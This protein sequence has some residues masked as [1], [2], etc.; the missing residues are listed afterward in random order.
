M[1]DGTLVEAS[2]TLRWLG[3]WFDRK[4][5]FKHHVKTKAASAMR[6]FLAL[7]RLGNTERGLSQ[8]AL[9]QLYQTCVT[10]IS[11]FGAEVWWN[12]QT[13]Y[14][15]QLQKIQ[16][17]AMRTITG[18]FRTTSISALEAETALL[19]TEIR[20]DLQQQKY[21]LRILSMPAT[22]SICT[23]SPD[24]FPSTQESGREE[25]PS[26]TPWHSGGA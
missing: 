22:H 16:N 21:A 9:R 1:P 13:G 3:I 19:P 11:D 14:K 8:T 23:F 4:L 12:G 17:N 5:S 26:A 6:A 15:I 18:A 24:S 7:A 10:T 25:E 2:D 20:L